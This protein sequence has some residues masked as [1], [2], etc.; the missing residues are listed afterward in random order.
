MNTFSKIV[1]LFL[2]TQNLKYCLNVLFMKCPIYELSCLWN[3]LSMILL[4]IKCSSIKCLSMKWPNTT[5]TARSIWKY[6][7]DPGKVYSVSKF[8][9]KNLKFFDWIRI[10]E[11]HQ[12]TLHGKSAT[13]FIVDSKFMKKRAS[14][15][16]RLAMRILN[17]E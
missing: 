17:H 11:I 6:K 14:R 2:H 16:A 3:V 13:F 7:N 1:T 12:W 4:F 10:F 15:A 9:K 8:L 5:K